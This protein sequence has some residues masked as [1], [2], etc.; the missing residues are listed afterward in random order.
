[1]SDSRYDHL[2]W[3]PD[4]AIP[5]QSSRVEKIEH[6]KGASF[7]HPERNPRYLNAIA[8][9]SGLDDLHA[10]ADYSS[11]PDSP[12]PGWLRTVF[13]QKTYTALER[14]LA[15]NEAILSRQLFGKR[16]GVI[17]Q[18]FWYHKDPNDNAAEGRALLNWFYRIRYTNNTEDVVGY[19]MLSGVIIKSV[20][21]KAVEMLPHERENFFAMVEAYDHAVRMNMYDRA[22]NPMNRLDP[23]QEAV[24]N[25]RA[26]ETPLPAQERYVG[27][28][29]PDEELDYILTQPTLRATKQAIIDSE[30]TTL[31]KRERA[32]ATARQAV[33]DAYPMPA[34]QDDFRLAA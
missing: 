6:E 19:R 25:Q 5:P 33:A 32:E 11:L 23:R 31:S 12:M 27:E 28:V 4:S 29:I 34:S 15:K 20:N 24:L 16:E 22:P 2:Y 13:A 18:E 14:D 21:G 17:F 7:F 10:T 1:M 30:L 3:K 8:I 9:E 26:H